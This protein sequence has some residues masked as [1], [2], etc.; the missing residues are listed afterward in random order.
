MD[1]TQADPLDVLDAQ[2]LFALGLRAS[3][4]GN[5]AAAL[6][7]L[8]RAV[9]KAPDHAQAHWAL[10]AEYAALRMPD[11]AAEHFARTIAIAPDQPIAR[12]QYGLLRLTSGDVAMATS[13]WAPLDTLPPDHPVRQFKQGLL[14]MV[15]DEFEPALE[16]IRAAA[17]HPNVDPALRRDMEM[18]ISRIETARAAPPTDATATPQPNAEPADVSAHSH[19]ALSAYSSGG[20]RR[21]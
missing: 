19:L 6:A 17:S 5:S 9:T 14:H 18:T 21:H 13:L 15:A 12:F 1:A 11:R 8:K 20:G 2:E 7:Y 16:R 4:G 3:T 10:A